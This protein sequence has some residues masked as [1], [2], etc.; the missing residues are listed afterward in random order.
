MR[1]ATLTQSKMVNTNMTEQTQENVWRLEE[2]SVEN[3]MQ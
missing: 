3:E 2:E 1:E